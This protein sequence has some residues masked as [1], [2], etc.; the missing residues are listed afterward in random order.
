M[1]NENN[2]DMAIFPIYGIGW[3][4]LLDSFLILIATE[5]LAGGPHVASTL[6]LKGTMPHLTEA[7]G[8]IVVL[9]T[10]VNAGSKIEKV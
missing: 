10:N 6:S 2:T 4:Q 1:L 9:A 5:N 8:K 3:I 7:L